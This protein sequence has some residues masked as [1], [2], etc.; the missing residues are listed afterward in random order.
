MFLQLNLL[1]DG[2]KTRCSSRSS[3]CVGTTKDG[4]CNTTTQSAA[5]SRSTAASWCS[6]SFIS[7]AI[8]GHCKFN[9]G[10]TDSSAEPSCSDNT[11]P[12]FV[13]IVRDAVTKVDD[14]LCLYLYTHHIMFSLLIWLKLQLHGVC[15]LIK[16]TMIHLCCTSEIC[17]QISID[18]FMVWCYW[19]IVYMLEV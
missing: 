19:H 13:H 5:S 2:C 14:S 17:W 18:R 3:N 11:T 12:S 7:S 15:L 4:S 8:S 6:A 9:I 1:D 10:P 16:C